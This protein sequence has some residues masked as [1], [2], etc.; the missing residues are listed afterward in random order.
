[1]KHLLPFYL[2]AM[3]LTSCGEQTQPVQ[4]Q[5]QESTYHDNSGREDAWSGGVR[6]IPIQTE[7][8]EFKVWTKRTGNNPTM[9]LLL[10]HGGP[11]C[12]SMLTYMQ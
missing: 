1:M 9:K 4:V 6:M 10:L 2:L 8:G 3:L 11:G 12:I 5:I 7:K